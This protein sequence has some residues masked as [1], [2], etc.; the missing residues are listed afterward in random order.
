MVS[1]TLEQLLKL[2]ANERVELALALW[3]S[4]ADVDREDASPI[5]DELRASL[6]REMAEHLNDPD[7]SI[8][9]ET[10]RQRLKGSG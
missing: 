10:V 2:P 5:S 8:P 3:E 4:L 6:D 7:S 9:W 1:E